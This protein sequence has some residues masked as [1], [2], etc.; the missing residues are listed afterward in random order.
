MYQRSVKSPF[1][2]AWNNLKLMNIPQLLRN[3]EP[4]VDARVPNLPSL[5]VGSCVVETAHS[6]G[7]SLRDDLVTYMFKL[8]FT[9]SWR[10]W[11]H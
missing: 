8:C 9:E 4:N 2:L 3:G 5:D 10:L 7:K 1:H 11:K 6:A